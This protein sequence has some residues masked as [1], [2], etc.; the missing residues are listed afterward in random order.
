MKTEE[1]VRENL[2]WLQNRCSEVERSLLGE[3]RSDVA[4]GDI[5]RVVALRVERLRSM[6][7]ELEAMKWVLD[8]EE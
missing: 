8:E 7:L 5:L 4:G 3:I 6:Y 1:E 2:E